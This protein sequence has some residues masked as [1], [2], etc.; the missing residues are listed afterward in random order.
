MIYPRHDISMLGC[1]VIPV[2]AWWLNKLSVFL[3]HLLLFSS[4]VCHDPAPF[5]C[6]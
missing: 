4:Y 5:L 2:S 6:T 3:S 1:F